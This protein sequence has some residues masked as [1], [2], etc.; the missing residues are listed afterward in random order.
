M[1]VPSSLRG[2]GQLVVITKTNALAEHTIKVCS[3]EK[4]FPIIKTYG[5]KVDVSF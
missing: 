5:G 1:S 2:E 4:L 3:N